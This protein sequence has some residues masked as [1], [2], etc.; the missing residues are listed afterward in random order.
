[1]KSLTIPNLRT[2]SIGVLLLGAGLVLADPL[3]LSNT[4]QND[5]VADADEVNTNFAEVV[6]ESDENDARVTQI[7]QDYDVDIANGNTVLANGLPNPITAIAGYLEPVGSQNTALGVSALITNEAGS[8]NTA[9]GFAALSTANADVDTVVSESGNYTNVFG[10]F[11]NS[12]LG[13]NALAA[14][15]TGSLNTAIGMDALKNATGD[16]SSNTAVGASSLENM[17]E[18]YAN[19]ALGYRAMYSSSGNGEPIALS[20]NVAVGAF[21]MNF[22]QGGGANVGVGV[23]ALSGNNTGSNN[24]AAGYSALSNNRTGGN[25]TALGANALSGNNSGVG[26]TGVGDAAMTGN[27]NGSNNTAVGHLANVA[28][29]S[30]TNATAIGYQATA[31]ANNE[32]RL[33]NGAVET[34]VTAGTLTLD[35]ITYPNTDGNTDQVLVTDGAGQAY[36]AD[37]AALPG[38]AAREQAFWD[39]IAQ[40]ETALEEQQAEMLA[41]IARQQEQLAQIERLLAGEHFVSR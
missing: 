33:G 17:D 1:M 32:I 6:A 9:V 19:T 25:N 36:W 11:G 18:G 27:T 8:S 35:V 16:T 20:N 12:A 3:V 37:V 29:G 2:T 22:T 24:T 14:T 34:V 26:N 31:A 4:F 5:Q 21:A 30:L 7:E 38:V 15:S 40:L 10:A 28:S 23:S 41:V 39:R 13:V